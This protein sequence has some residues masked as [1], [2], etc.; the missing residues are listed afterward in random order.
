MLHQ[1]DARDP[2]IPLLIWFAYEPHVPSAPNAALAWLQQS[3]PGNPMVLDAMVPRTL[4]RLAATGEPAVLAACVEFFGVMK[5][6]RVRIKALEGFIQGIENRQTDPPPS[7]KEVFSALRQ[8]RTR[9][10]SG[11][12]VA[13]PFIFGI[14]KH[15]VAP[16]GGARQSEDDLRNGSMLFATWRWHT[17]RKPCAR[18]RIYSMVKRIPASLRSLPGPG[19][20]RSARNCPDRPCWM[21]RYPP[22]VRIEAVNLLAERKEWARRA[23]R[24]RGQEGSAAAPI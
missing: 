17:Q 1:E 20:L 3:A 2:C 23:A 16:G 8:D 10:C 14:R 9:N 6:I 19:K 7:W 13:W 4:R 12:P 22:T 18:W 24:R 5:D 15:S 11:L 21:E